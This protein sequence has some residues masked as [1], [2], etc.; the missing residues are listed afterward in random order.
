[1][2]KMNIDIKEAQ[3]KYQYQLSCPIEYKMFVITMYINTGFCI[4]TKA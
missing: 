3:H 2:R 4:S 1:M